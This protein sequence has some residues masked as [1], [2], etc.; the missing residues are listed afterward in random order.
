M[1]FLTKNIIVLLQNDFFLPLYRNY[2]CFDGSISQSNEVLYSF[3]KVCVLYCKIINYY[4]IKYSFSYCISISYF[5]MIMNPLIAHLSITSN[6]I[7][8]PP[9]S[10]LPLAYNTNRKPKKPDCLDYLLLLT[11]L[12]RKQLFDGHG[13]KGNDMLI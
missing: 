6:S 2:L 4:E 8:V 7:E 12:I 9:K 1:H 5:I 13:L 10:F 3:L 11:W